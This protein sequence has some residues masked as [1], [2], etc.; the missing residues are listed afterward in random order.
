ML[1]RRSLRAANKA[2]KLGQEQDSCQRHLD[3]KQTGRRLQIAATPRPENATTRNSDRRMTS[4][5]A[6]SSIDSAGFERL[7]L[8]VLCLS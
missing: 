3:S 5:V 4:Q 7:G 8:S 6:H 1:C 2:S